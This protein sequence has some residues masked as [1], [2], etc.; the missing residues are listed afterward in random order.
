MSDDQMIRIGVLMGRVEIHVRDRW[1]GRRLIGEGRRMVYD[2]DGI[3]THMS[4]WE[5][6][7]VVLI[8][9]EPDDEPSWLGGLMRW[10]GIW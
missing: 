8:Y 5:P 6:T 9:P 1:E 7:G 2:A 4:E 3:L 10:M